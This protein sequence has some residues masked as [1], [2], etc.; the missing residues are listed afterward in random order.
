MPLP[1]RRTVVT[2]WGTG[3]LLLLPCTAAHR[4]WPRFLLPSEWAPRPAPHPGTSEPH[5]LCPATGACKATAFS[6][7]RVAS[8]GKNL[9]SHPCP[10]L[11]SPRPQGLITGPP[12]RLTR[13]GWGEAAVSCSW[14]EGRVCTRAGLS[15]ARA[16]RM[17]SASGC[18][19]ASVCLRDGPPL[20]APRALPSA[21]R[22]R[23]L[24]QGVCI[25]VTHPWQWN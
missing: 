8:Q 9:Y 1:G 20:P 18:V 16:A 25:K 6:E 4:R 22:S 17:G 11:P 10:S 24:A 23:S 14:G 5:L 2:G 19:R 3:A 13:P 15:P 12:D 21:A 7:P